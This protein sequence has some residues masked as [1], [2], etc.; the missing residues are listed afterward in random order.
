MKSLIHSLLALG[1]GAI[2]DLL[3]SVGFHPLAPPR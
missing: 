3:E 1:K 2:S